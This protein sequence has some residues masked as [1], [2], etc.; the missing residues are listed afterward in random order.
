MIC[1]ICEQDFKI[2]E[3]SKAQNR[4]LCYNCIPEGI[5]KLERDRLYRI[6][7]KQKVDIEKLTRGCDCCGYKKCASALEWHHPNNDKVVNPAN[8]LRS[9]GYKGY[10]RYK[11]EIKKC[12]LLCANCHREKHKDL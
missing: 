1:L 3:N 12:S 9:N 5:T 7:I 6:L 10:L 2:K 11:Q 8:C 4:K